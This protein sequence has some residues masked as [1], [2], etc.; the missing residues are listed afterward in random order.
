MGLEH[1]LPGATLIG[2]GA[3]PP[4]MA[5]IFDLGGV[6]LGRDSADFY[7]LAPSTMG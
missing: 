6:E 4:D 5:W 1:N 2:R 3:E 7:R